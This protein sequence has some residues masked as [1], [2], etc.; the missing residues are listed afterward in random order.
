V[1][2]YR[3]GECVEK[4]FE[5]AGVEGFVEA[6]VLPSDQIAQG[7]GRRLHDCGVLHAHGQR[8]AHSGS[9]GHEH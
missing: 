3:V 8:V 4:G 7:K 2:T 1:G 6:R 5:D 9:G